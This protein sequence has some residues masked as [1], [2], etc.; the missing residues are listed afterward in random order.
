MPVTAVD[1][2]TAHC[3]VVPE[4]ARKQTFTPNKRRCVEAAKLFMPCSR[5][6]SCTC[7]ASAEVSDEG[8]HKQGYAETSPHTKPV[9]LSNQAKLPECLQ[10]FVTNASQW[11]DWRYNSKIHY[12]KQGDTGPAVLLIHGFGVGAFH[13]DG[14]ISQLSSSCQV[15][16]IDLLGQGMSWPS[17]QPSQGGRRCTRFIVQPLMHLPRCAE[18][19]HS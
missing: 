1:R 15:W 7:K 19:M 10:P 17:T 18:H 3:V 13:F 5:Q 16:A 11:W 14:L 6:L 9:T 8:A 12:R 2:P 4:A